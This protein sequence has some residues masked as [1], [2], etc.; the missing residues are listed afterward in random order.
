M[1]ELSRVPGGRVPQGVGETFDPQVTCA[2]PR[3]EVSGVP[4]EFGP[5]AAREG[6]TGSS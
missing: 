1:L 3:V 4:R 5:A 6:T 2:S